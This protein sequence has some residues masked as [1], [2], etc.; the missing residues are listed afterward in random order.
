MSAHTDST[1]TAGHDT[2]L[3]EWVTK[4]SKGLLWLFVF[5]ALDVA[6]IL[7]FVT[8]W[9]HDHH[10]SP[11]AAAHATTNT[12]TGVNT[13]RAQD[14]A[15]LDPRTI[16][17]A[18]HDGDSSPL[19]CQ[20]EKDGSRPIPVQLSE[21]THLCFVGNPV[22]HGIHIFE[23]SDDGVEHVLGEP[24]SRIISFRFTSDNG[25]GSV[26]YFASPNESC[27]ST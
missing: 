20:A 14:Q 11:P 23:T 27:S 18:I 22:A 1:S 8:R 19:I 6:I 21:T 25:K 13:G 17:P 2:W 3:P 24:V 10:A 4:W 9:W 5:I 16:C 26:S 15:P 12:S 7:P